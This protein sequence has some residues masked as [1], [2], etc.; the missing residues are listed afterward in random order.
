MP[1]WNGIGIIAFPLRHYRYVLVYVSPAVV[2]NAAGRGIARQGGAHQRAYFYNYS[3]PPPLICVNSATF[4]FPRSSFRVPVA[5]SVSGRRTG[6]VASVNAIADGLITR[7]RRAFMRYT[8]CAYGLYPCDIG[9]KR[10]RERSRLARSRYTGNRLKAYLDET[11]FY[12][13]R[14]PDLKRPTA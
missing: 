13:R 5:R 7:C 9:R 6:I 11:S 4:L 3:R 2:M 8:P 10:G 1:Y 12:A 14:R